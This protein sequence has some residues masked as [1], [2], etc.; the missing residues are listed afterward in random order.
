[1]VWA[2]KKSTSPAPKVHQKVPQGTY[3]IDFYIGFFLNLNKSSLKKN[4]LKNFLM[5]FLGWPGPRKKFRHPQEGKHI[6]VKLGPPRG[7]L[8]SKAVKNENLET[9]PQKV[10]QWKKYYLETWAPPQASSQAKL[11]KI[12]IG[13]WTTK[14]AAMKK[15]YRE[16]WASTRPAP[17][18]SSQNEN[19]E[20][21]PPKMRWLRNYFSIWPL[22]GQAGDSQ[23]SKYNN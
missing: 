10:Q 4:P 19:L 23:L 16:I 17:K 18:Q 5:N 14:N 13:N 22:T 9:G 7:Q 3:F 1:M 21:G 15:S 20:I 6:T 2:K 12:K 11:W 8:P